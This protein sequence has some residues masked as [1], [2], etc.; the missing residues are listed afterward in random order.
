V[1]VQADIRRFESPEELAAA[2]A[3][4]IRRAAADARLPR[5]TLVLAGGGTP[6]PVYR[7]L[8]ADPETPWGRTLLF[9]GDERC[10][11][12]DAP[13]SNWGAALRALAGAPIPEAAVF[14]VRGELPPAE[15]AAEYEGRIRAVFG[16][17][18]A[19]TAPP[20][21]DLILLGMGPDGHTASLFPGSPALDERRR[22]VTHTPAPPLEP[23]VPRVT[24]TLPVLNAARQVVF[25]VAGRQ[26]LDILD[27]ILRNPEESARRYPAARIRR[28]V[29]FV[30]PR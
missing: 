4:R 6:Q 17:P 29:W 2:A 21:F 1:T 26:K 28:A 10:V 8:A 23:R 5:F 27:E 30:C 24:M 15:A 22:W 13:E 12:R 3:E 18:A 9:Q 16:L 19:E 11:P 25:L 14:A 7:R 20:A